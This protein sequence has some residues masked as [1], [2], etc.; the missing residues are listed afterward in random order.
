M[1]KTRLSVLVLMSVLCSPITLKADEIS[2]SLPASELAKYSD[3]FDT[4]RNDLWERQQYTW[5]EA[6]R[7]NFKLADITI[8]DGRL[9]VETQTGGFSKAALNGKFFF[10]GDFDIQ[11]GVSFEFIVLEKGKSAEDSSFS[12]IELLKKEGHGQ[13]ALMTICYS[14]RK[15][16]QPN[17]RRV[18]AFHGT[19]R[20]VRK[21]KTVRSLCQD[22]GSSEWKEIYSCSCTDRDVFVGIGLSNFSNT[23]SSIKADDLISAT[24][25]N[26]KI[27]AAQGIVESEI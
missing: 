4:L 23:R 27:N 26:F 1:W 24:F 5:N 2:N 11:V 9:K 16:S 12:T 7:A 18:D 25:D 20:F 22:K 19:L 15:F 14:W 17:E 13:G 10:R 3:S 21:G 8:Q 6:Q